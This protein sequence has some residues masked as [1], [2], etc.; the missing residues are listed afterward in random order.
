MVENQA[1]GNAQQPGTF[2]FCKIFLWI[3]KAPISRKQKLENRKPEK[4]TN[5]ISKNQHFS[6][7]GIPG[8][9]NRVRSL[10]FAEKLSATRF[11]TPGS[12][13]TVYDGY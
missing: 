2:G 6:L 10:F 7:A 11:I 9:T 8:D 5:T 4:P 12:F 13:N 3:A 1:G